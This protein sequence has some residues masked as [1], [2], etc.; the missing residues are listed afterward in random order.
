[1]KIKN[2]NHA[3]GNSL[4]L[5][6]LVVCANFIG[7]DKSDEGPDR[8]ALLD[9]YELVEESYTFIASAAKYDEAG[10]KRAQEDYCQVETEIS[11][12]SRE[13]NVLTIEVESPKNCDVDYE[14]IWNG[15][16]MYSD[17]MQSAIY[18]R[19]IAEDCTDVSETEIDVLTIDLEETLQSLTEDL[20]GNRKEFIGRINFLIRDA[21]SLVDVVCDDN[22]NVTVSD[23]D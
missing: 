19:A 2:R 7:C 23:V 20:V 4:P 16:V 14:I 5:L 6:L 11:K 12:V 18:I 13:G 21:C 8:T 1:M 22:C 15:E 9:D 3:F 17:P 10:E